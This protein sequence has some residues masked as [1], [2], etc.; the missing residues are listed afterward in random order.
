ASSDCRKIIAFSEFAKRNFVATHVGFEEYDALTSKLTV[1]YPN[2]VLPPYKSPQRPR[3]EELHIVFVGAHF[4]RKGGAVAVRAA[5][6]ARQRRLPIHFHVISSL[7]VGPSVW[8]DPHDKDFFGPYLELL[9]GTNVTH[10]PSMPNERVIDLL[11][12][13]DFTILTTLSDT[14]G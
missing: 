5:E 3:R 6:I 12:D 11:R 10:Y 13:A 2:M 7:K 8:S 9:S 14:F 4:G 1:V